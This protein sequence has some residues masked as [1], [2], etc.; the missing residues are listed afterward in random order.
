MPKKLPVF[1]THI[2]LFLLLCLCAGVLF[3]FTLEEYWNKIQYENMYLELPVPPVFLYIFCVLSYLLQGL[4]FG[5]V[6]EHSKKMV[7]ETAVL[8]F[9][10]QFILGILWPGIF[11]GLRFFGMALTDLFIAFMLLIFTFATFRKIDLL[12]AYMLIPYG[13]LLI[14]IS[15]LNAWFFLV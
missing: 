11:F 15:A 9:W 12:A 3:A 7:Y 5:I 1:K 4:A 10:T 8:L 2:L 14:F 13:C 6:S